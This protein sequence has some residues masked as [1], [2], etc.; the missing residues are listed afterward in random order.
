M[1][2]CKKRTIYRFVL[3]LSLISLLFFVKTNYLTNAFI[4]CE[5]T[6]NQI[7]LRSRIL[8]ISNEVKK[9]LSIYRFSSTYIHGQEFACGSIKKNR[10]TQKSLKHTAPYTA[11]DIL[12]VVPSAV[13]NVGRRQK[14]R[15]SQLYAFAQDPANKARLLFFLGSPAPTQSEAVRIQETIDAEVRHHGDIV[16]ELYTDVYRNILLK[17]VAMLRWASTFCTHANYVIRTDDDVIV[18]VSRLV[19][20]IHDVARNHSHFILAG[21]LNKNL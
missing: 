10:Q 7:N 14:V 13:G 2:V 3:P 20:A 16:Q 5:N 8:D 17:A 1:V 6:L 4:R 9:F 15:A 21:R 12:F 18:D 11:I 19:S